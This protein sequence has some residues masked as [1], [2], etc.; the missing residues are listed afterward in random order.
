MRLLKPWFVMFL[1]KTFDLAKRTLFRRTEFPL[2]EAT[3]RLMF[4]NMSYSAQKATRVL[5][6]E[7]RPTQDTFADQF[8]DLAC[9]GLLEASRELE[10]PSIW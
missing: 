9:R 4:A 2:S 5:G 6:F 7:P 1:G 10:P 8:A 3:A